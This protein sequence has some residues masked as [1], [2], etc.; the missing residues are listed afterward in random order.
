MESA[1]L[2]SSLAAAVWFI[3]ISIGGFL[4]KQVW[5]WWRKS[6]DDTREFEQQQRAE[7][8]QYHRQYEERLLEVL[9]NNA[10]ANDRVDQAV[11]GMVRAVEGMMSYLEDM[12]LRD[13][14]MQHH[15]MLIQ[16]RNK[17]NHTAIA[18]ALEHITKRQDQIAS[19]VFA[20]AIG[21][22]PERAT[23]YTTLIRRVEEQEAEIRTLRG[24]SYTPADF[25][26]YSP[27]KTH[28]EDN[29]GD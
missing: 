4:S 28:E 1:E 15:L 9:S 22:T 7:N 27:L 16:E 14:R 29:S 17:A 25:D 11:K 26:Y 5:D 13:E 24:K 3:V 20:Y 2:P 21:R 12:S 18:D 8:R 19:E 10:R 23:D 6:S